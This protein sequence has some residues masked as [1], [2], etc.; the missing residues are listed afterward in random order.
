MCKRICDILEKHTQLNKLSA[1]RRFY[2]AK[3]EEVENDLIFTARSRQLADSVKSISVYLKDSEMTM[4]LLNSLPDHLDP[5]ISTLHTSH[6][7][8]KNF[9]F[10]FVQSRCVQEEQRFTQRHSSALKVSESAAL[11][12]NNSYTLNQSRLNKSSEICIHCG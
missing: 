9:T 3:M 8:E 1:R 10:E 7:D 2:N 12:A 5:L 4:V 11:F 6:S